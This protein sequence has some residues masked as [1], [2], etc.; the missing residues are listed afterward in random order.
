RLEGA[1]QVQPGQTVSAVVA[2]NCAVACVA[3]TG[4]STA[5]RKGARLAVYGTGEGSGVVPLPKRTRRPS[6]V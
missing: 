4:A 6:G 1:L 5:D 2:H 3:D